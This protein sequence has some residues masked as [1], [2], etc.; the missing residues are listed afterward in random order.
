MGAKEGRPLRRP[1]R[2]YVHPAGVGGECRRLAC[3]DPGSIKGPNGLERGDAAG[4]LLFFREDVGCSAIPAEDDEASDVLVMSV[5]VKP[6]EPGWEG[7]LETTRWR[8]WEPLPI[9][10]EDADLSADGSGIGVRLDRVDGDHAL[11]EIH[12]RSAGPSR[13]FRIDGDFSAIV[14]APSS[15]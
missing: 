5:G 3:P 15:D 11:G 6:V 10:D 13:A 7:A 12:I 1:I 9:S 14:C 8:R 4:R 2:E